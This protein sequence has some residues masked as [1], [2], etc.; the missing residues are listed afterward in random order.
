MNPK[1][2]KSFL[3]T[4]FLLLSASTS[5]GTEFN[6]LEQRSKGVSGLQQDTWQI[7]QSV[8]LSAKGLLWARSSAIENKYVDLICQNQSNKEI[9]ITFN[10]PNKPWFLINAN[11]TCEN[12]QNE[13]LSCK[14]SGGI[15]AA[16]RLVEKNASLMRA[17]GKQGEQTAVNL[18]S[19]NTEDW[20]Q[21]AESVFD[22]YSASLDICKTLHGSQH[23]QGA[24]EFEISSS[25]STTAV[26]VVQTGD[27]ATPNS[28]MDYANCVK[29]AIE[30]WKFPAL[31][32][33]YEPMLFTFED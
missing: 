4:L 16:C 29:S 27:Y 18:R 5:A 28:E 20:Y 22:D 12:W 9:E 26:A 24:V 32:T 15:V 8:N 25:G 11:T 7:N 17:T 30:A 10:Q 3:Q 31:I 13:V 23:K 19:L 6:L 2:F 1:K 33:G 14:E 21:V